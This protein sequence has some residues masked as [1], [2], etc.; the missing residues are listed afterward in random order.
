M[1]ARHRMDA[2]QDSGK[3]W[4]VGGG[5]AGQRGRM[6]YIQSPLSPGWRQLM[7]GMQLCTCALPC[8]SLKHVDLGSA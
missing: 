5:R 1:D 8:S 2:R 3:A 7:V 4:T 6:A